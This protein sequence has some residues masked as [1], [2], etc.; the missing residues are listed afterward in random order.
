[1]YGVTQAPSD[2]E[3]LQ[4]MY[5]ERLAAMQV[6]LNLT[7]LELNRAEK[8]TTALRAKNAVLQREVVELR[9]D[10]Q[11]MMNVVKGKFIHFI[12]SL[13]TCIHIVPDPS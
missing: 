13:V 8:E 3:M 9:E 5:E 11:E 2:F 7:K 1:M 6:A 12:I 4:T 10:R